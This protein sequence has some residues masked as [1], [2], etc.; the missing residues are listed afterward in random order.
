MGSVRSFDML[1]V[2]RSVLRR[3][4][5]SEQRGLDLPLDSSASVHHNHP[6]HGRVALCWLSV[7]RFGRHFW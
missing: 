5:R 6:D 1:F 3:V 7:D 4:E 2:R